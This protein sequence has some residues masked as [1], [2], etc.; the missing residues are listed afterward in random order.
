MLESKYFGRHQKLDMTASSHTPFS[1]SRFPRSRPAL[2]AAAIAFAS[3]LT[4]SCT[5]TDSADSPDDGA[6]MQHSEAV[7]QAGTAV[8]KCPVMHDGSAAEDSVAEAM[9]SRRSEDAPYEVGDW[10]P[11]LLDLSVL[12]QNAPA[13]NPMGEDFDYAEAF[14]QLDLAALKQDIRAVL[15]DSQEWWPADWGH[16]G[17]LMIRLA[18]HSAGTYRETDGRGGSASGTIRLAPLGSWPDNANLDKARRLLWPVKKKYGRNISWAD[19]IVLAGNVSLESMGFETLGFGGGRDD[20]YE[21]QDVNWGPEKEMLTADRFSGDRELARP[22]GASEMGLIYVNP[23]GPDGVPDPKAAAHDIRVTFGRMAMNDEETVALI[24]GG[25]T[26]GKVHGAA[27]GKYLGPEPE[28]A[29]IEQQGLGWKNAFGS[30][31]GKDAI[32][33]GLEGA[34]TYTPTEWSHDYLSNLFEYEWEVYKGP[35]GAWQ[36]RPQEGEA[37]GR[38]VPDAHDPEERDHV[39]MLTTDIAL[40]EDPIYRDIAERFYENPEAFKAAFARAWFKLTHRDMGPASRLLGPEV[41]DPQLWQDPIPAVDHELVGDADVRQ[42]K[43]KVLESG[44]SVPQLVR[45]AWA[46]ASTYRESDKRGGANG[47]RVRLAPQNAWPVNRPEELRQ[48][49]EQLERIRADFND[50]QP[51]DGKRIS[52]A[53]LI[54]LAGAA[55]IEKA[56]SDAGFDVSV[57]FLPGRMDATEEMT[58]AASFGVLEPRADAF[59]NYAG[60]S[61]DRPTPELLVDRSALLTLSAPEMTVLLGGMRALDANFD[62]SDHGVFTKRP[63]TLTNDFFVNLL[64]MNTVWEPSGDGVYLGR[65]RSTGEVVWTGTDVDLIFGANSQLRAIAE[66][67]G[68]DDAGQKFVDD[69]VAAWHKV[70]TLDRFE[71]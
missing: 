44:L 33:S 70:M 5:V 57:P 3:L 60:P 28:A 26:L 18:W 27:P 37:D 11:N 34:W 52:L 39:I 67:Y 63:G 53:D 38:T 36:W 41:P 19:L 13:S 43:A 7:V 49:L 15:T 51:S 9:S 40:K 69:F 20:V 66:V 64:D 6:T 35:G 56:A 62:G 50:A 68:A 30:G 12:H 45:T 46:S 29:P 17:G 55:A 2:G 21:P 48:V 59:R 32:T 8:A 54:V 42:L 61:A 58:D 4:V 10:W 47:A 25:H 65:D 23:Q 14:A 16:Y 24:A 71:L 31:K 1:S 22:L